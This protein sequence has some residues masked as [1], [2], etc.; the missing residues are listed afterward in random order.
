MDMNR[1]LHVLLLAILFGPQVGTI[2]VPHEGVCQE[3][4]DCCPPGAVCDVNCVSC[5]CCSK[6]TN[7][8][9]IAALG[10]TT[11]VSDPATTGPG[12]IALPLFPT[13]ILH[14]PKSV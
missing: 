13:E 5:A 14:V 3:T 2:L 4:S 9:S 6:L 8:S 1:L 12:S 11:V 10:P 7:F